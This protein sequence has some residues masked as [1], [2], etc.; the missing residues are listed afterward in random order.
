MNKK[1]LVFLIV[2][3]I[4]KPYVKKS[5]YYL[6]LLAM[7]APLVALMPVPGAA[8]LA[9]FEAKLAETCAGPNAHLRQR[10]RPRGCVRSFSGLQRQQSH[11]HGH[12]SRQT[13]AF[14]G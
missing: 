1:L 9:A 10:R 7:A 6:Q 12:R 13:F 11:C 8:S 2:F 4:Y 3:V 14:K 5:H